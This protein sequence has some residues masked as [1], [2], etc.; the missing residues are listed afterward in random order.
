MSL[1]VVPLPWVTMAAPALSSMQQPGSLAFI[2]GP[3][4][5]ARDLLQI[6]GDTLGLVPVSVTALILGPTAVASAEELHQR[7]AGHPLFYDLESLCW[8]PWLRLDL[9]RSLRIQARD[10]WVL[11][12]WPGTYT[13][14]RLVFS[15]PSR[16][17]YVEFEARELTLIHPIPT[18]FP[19]EV[20]F[21]LE[22]MPT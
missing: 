13:G 3:H 4:Q 17:D 20:P 19:D 9:L 11:A 18:R 10:S 6:L 16:P 14:K 21:I 15:E 8:Q 5:T 2:L 7:L 22:R 12:I 1:G